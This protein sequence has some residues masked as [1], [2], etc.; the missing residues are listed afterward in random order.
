MQ[1]DVLKMRRREFMGAVAG[2]WS[3]LKPGA[4]Y[5]AGAAG[6]AGTAGVAPAAHTFG[7]KGE[8][9]LLDDQPFQ[10][11][12]GEIHYARVPR[13][14][15]RDRLRKIRSM[16]L[17]TICTYMFWNMHE[18]APGAFNF[19]GNLDAA[20]FIRAA[21]EEALWVILRP[22]PYSCGEWDFG[23]YPAWLLATPDMR[24]RS[25]DPRFLEAARKY[26][27]EVGRQLAPLQITRDG[28]IL[29]VQL[30]NEY[31]SFGHDH[32]YM[33]SIEKMIRDSGFDATLYT[34]DGSW[35]AE[36]AGGTLPD[37]LSAINFGDGDDPAKEFANFAK[38][39]HGVPRMNAEFWDGW[40]DH[41]G[42]AHHVS[43]PEAATKG[44]DWMLSQGISVSLYMV[45]GGTSFGFMSGANYN[46]AYQ[47]DISS[48]DYDSPIDEAGRPTRK[49]EAIRDVIQ[50]H[51]PAG[52]RLPP[53]PAALPMHEIPTF[54]LAESAPLEPLLSRPI[55]SE[56]PKTME[57]VGQSYGFILYRTTMEKAAHGRLEIKEARD[58]AVVSQGE[59]RLGVLDRRLHQSTLEVNLEAGV[60]LDILVENMGR[61]NFGPHLVDDRKGIT[62]RVTLDGKELTGWEIY[63]LPLTDL[64]LLN[65]TSA[66]EPA[67]AFHRGAFELDTV[68][69]V[70]LDLRGWGKGYV[71][72]NGH[73][74]GRYWRI[75]PQQSLFLPG[76]WLR[77]GKNEVIVLDLEDSAHRSLTGRREPVW[78]NE[79]S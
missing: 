54:Q 28:P 26:M 79:S 61:V 34:A 60:P 39:R 63:S 59:K 72:V 38:F 29:M 55:R 2:A 35:P 10:I 43:S 69:D 4:V 77:Q 11:I 17:N 58:Y 75:G 56:R 66:R 40:F 73:N 22:G 70:F 1:G 74:L 20:A 15:W 14:Y 65:F 31:G 33:Q 51:L 30:E 21:Q 3:L 37:V 27:R 68:G 49:F 71:W 8:H 9:F 24:V 42:E 64:S 5:A 48:Y 13:E 62:E 16:G 12:A 57:A 50:E 7:Q 44:L 52:T 36:L 78:G 45:H 46:K 41:W 6:A 32:A 67:P 19:E 23:G 47:P 76:P 25:T 53:L 18:P